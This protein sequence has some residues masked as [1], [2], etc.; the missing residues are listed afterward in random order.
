M[1][2]EKGY[3]TA[4]DWPTVEY[5]TRYGDSITVL[6]GTAGAYANNREYLTIWDGKGSPDVYLMHDYSEDEENNNESF[7]N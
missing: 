1:N 2:P 5:L 4:T 3:T 7:G 6:L